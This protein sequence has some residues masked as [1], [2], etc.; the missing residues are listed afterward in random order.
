MPDPDAILRSM[1][2][3]SVKRMKTAEEAERR[4]LLAFR[5]GHFEEYWRRLGKEAEDRLEDEYE[6]SDPEA[7]DGGET[8]GGGAGS[9]VP[10][11]DRDGAFESSE[12]EP[13]ATTG[14]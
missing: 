13:P 1:Q 9:D 7:G 2:E 10:A 4:S 6:H 5:S 12:T 14:T 3:N 8:G 11:D